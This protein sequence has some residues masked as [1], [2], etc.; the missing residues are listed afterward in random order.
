MGQGVE[1]SRGAAR[2]RA[3]RSHL[4]VLDPV[5]ISVLITLVPH[6]IVVGVFLPRVGCQKAIVLKVGEEPRWGCGLTQPGRLNPARPLHPCPRLEGP[7]P[8]PQPGHPPLPACST[9]APARSQLPAGPTPAHWPHT[10]LQCLLLSMHG[11]A[12]SG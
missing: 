3:A 1:R 2:D 8:P 6:T 10:C 4:H 7:P 11:R 5:P 12:W 9:P